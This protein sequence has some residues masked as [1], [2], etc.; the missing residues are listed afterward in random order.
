[1]IPYQITSN[2]N[3]TFNLVATVSKSYYGEP[4]S[5]ILKNPGLARADKV[6]SQVVSVTQPI[7]IYV[8]GIQSYINSANSLY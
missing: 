6:A 1:M 7:Y 4:A 5:I 8:C 3:N 2:S